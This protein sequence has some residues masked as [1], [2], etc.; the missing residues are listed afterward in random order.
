MQEF[1][2][3]VK[4][5]E[6]EAVK[7]VLAFWPRLYSVLATDMEHRV[8]EAAHVAHLEVV[9][10]VKRNLAPFLKQLIGPWFTS[11][12]DNY[13]PAATAA[14]QSFEA[15]FPPNKTYEVIVFCEEE[16]LSYICDN[17]TNQTAETLSNIKVVSPEDA[18][19]KYERVLLSSLQGYALYLT[20]VSHEQIKKSEELNLKIFKH[21]NFWKLAKFKTTVVQA[22]F[23]GVLSAVGQNAPF[24][25]EAEKSQVASTVFTNL[26]RNEPTLLPKIWETAL[27]I[28]SNIKVDLN[29]FCLFKM[30]IKKKNT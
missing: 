3:L 12:Y 1:A 21:Q 10:K 28:T 18:E 8:R 22:A 9:S 14:K 24:L 30:C 17:L 2:E 29:L 7:A 23:F 19:A 25:Y 13:P 11:Q 26:D 6:P 4:S 27:L 16:I 20:K 5:S 15:A